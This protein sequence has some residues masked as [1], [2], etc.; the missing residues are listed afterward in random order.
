MKEN[1][2]VAVQ[3]YYK[4]STNYDHYVS[5]KNKDGTLGYKLIPGQRYR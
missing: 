4:I 5:F 1:I 2:Y 3:Q